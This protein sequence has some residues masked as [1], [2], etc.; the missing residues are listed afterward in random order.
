[1][2]EKIAK[3]NHKVGNSFSDRKTLEALQSATSLFSITDGLGSLFL[4]HPVYRIL[5]LTGGKS[6]IKEVL[7]QNEL[8][9]IQNC[10]KDRTGV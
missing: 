9:Y 4:G 2:S 10:L 8:M 1:M 5:V 3:N 7:S 6:Q